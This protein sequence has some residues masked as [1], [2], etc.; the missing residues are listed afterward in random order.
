MTTLVQKMMLWFQPER[1]SVNPVSDFFVRAK[2][3]EKKKKYTEAL[4]KAQKDQETILRKYETLK[5]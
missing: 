5:K 2:A 3:G 4:K 1:R